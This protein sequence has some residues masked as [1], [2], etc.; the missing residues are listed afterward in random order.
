MASLNS[1][2]S[3]IVNF[4]AIIIKYLSCFTLGK[5]FWLQQTGAAAPTA[6]QIS[7]R[8]V[9]ITQWHKSC[10]EALSD[11]DSDKKNCVLF[12]PN[13]VNCDLF[14]VIFRSAIVVIGILYENNGRT[15]SS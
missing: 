3:I 13:C 11:Y 9:F 7:L 15:V 6:G 14:F 12:I 2:Y 4:C 5:T 8:N 1:I 10:G